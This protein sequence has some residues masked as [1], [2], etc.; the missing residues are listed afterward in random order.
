MR[1]TVLLLAL[2]AA[3]AFAG[4]ARAYD[5][6]EYTTT[7]DG[8]VA[9]VD[10]TL[11]PGTEQSS[12]VAAFAAA[13]RAL[14]SNLF[15]TTGFV[16]A[17]FLTKP[18]EKAA[19]T[20]SYNPA[21]EPVASQQALVDA[22]QT[23]S[24]VPGSS[25]RYRFGGTTTRCPSSVGV[26][27]P[28]SLDGF[29]DV[30]WGPLPLFV[31]GLTVST[32]RTDTGA[33]L[34]SDVAL[35]SL[36]AAAFRNDGTD[37]DV[38]T[39]LL[40]EDGHVAGLDHT[41]DPAAVMNA[42]YHGV[43]R[44]LTTTD[45]DA[46]RFLYPR[47]LETLPRLSIV[48]QL[49]QPAPGGGVLQDEFELGGVGQGGDVVFVSDVPEGQGLFVGSGGSLR[50]LARSGQTT[51]GVPMGAGSF[52]LVGADGSGDVAFAWDLTFDIPSPFGSG[53]GLFLTQGTT[54]RALLLPGAPAPG[55]GTFLGFTAPTVSNRGD[56]AFVGV[57][58]G[59]F[60]PGYGIFLMR[61]D[62]TLVD[63]ARPGDPSP[64]GGIFVFAYAPEIASS[65]DV[66][67]RGTTTA[68][69]SAAYVWRSGVLESIAAP[70]GPAPGGGTWISATLPYMNARGDVLFGGAQF[71]PSGF[72]RGL[73]LAHDGVVSPVAQPGDV[74][75]DGWRFVTLLSAGRTWT[76]NDAGDVAFIATVRDDAGRRARAVYAGRPGALSLLAREGSVF[77]GIGAVWSIPSGLNGAVVGPNGDVAFEVE[78][79][80]RLLVLEARHEP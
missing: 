2:L 66:A 9:Q 42:T 34:E 79:F 48:A 49:G 55:G 76:M 59:P 1:T 22:E 75:P 68:L 56:V 17:Q 24:S 73:Y 60:G 29:N 70:G 69:G 52:D 14:P 7:I 10:V 36:A 5:G 12:A 57:V 33:G 6:L 51:A 58:D 20:Q 64:A 78:T 50:Q 30:G 63:V 44:S 4:A 16:W 15:A 80:Y 27:G 25:F 31:L 13:H 54:T 65:G 45:A 71:F 3:S 67:F 40:H 37:I 19:L 32:F 53:G 39:V 77:L 26:C 23:W 61:R 46:L 72:A 38:E 21:G 11:V 8:N 74:M 41:P 62:G 47:N 35:N 18:N 43:N 28:P